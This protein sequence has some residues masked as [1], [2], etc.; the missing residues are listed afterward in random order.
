M[1]CAWLAQVV[2]PVGERDFEQ[3]EATMLDSVRAMFVDIRE[4]YRQIDQARAE[5]NADRD[6]FDSERA[7]NEALFAKQQQELRDL[8][9]VRKDGRGMC[10]RRGVPQMTANA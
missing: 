9:E 4:E 2:A 8:Q 7:E 5:L 3:R 10:F 6:A 1:D